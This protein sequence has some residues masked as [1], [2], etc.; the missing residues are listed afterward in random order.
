MSTDSSATVHRFRVDAAHPCLPGH[1]PGHPLVPA[2]VLMEEVAH[3]VRELH[4]LRVARIVDA[5][6]LAPLAPGTEAEVRLDGAPPVCR[7]EVR[8]ASGVLARGRVA[9]S[10]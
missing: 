1:F 8:T 3:V 4:G 7:F 9:V 10:A 6:F 5:K 2:V